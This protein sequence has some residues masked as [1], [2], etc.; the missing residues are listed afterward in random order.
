MNEI[1]KYEE[2]KKKM[3]G[4]CDEHGLVFR[5]TKNRY[6]IVF[7][8]RPATDLDSQMDMLEN[9]E[10]VGYRSPDAAMIWTYPGK[11]DDVFDTRV[12]G[13]TFTI[14]RNLRTKI[15]SILLKMISF[16]Q[17]YF[18]RDVMEKEAIKAGMEPVIDEDEA[19][20]DDVLPDDDGELPMEDA[21]ELPGDEDLPPLEDEDP[22]VEEATKIVRAENKATNALLQ[23]RM[24]I[25]Y[26]KAARLMNKLEEMGVVG[27]FNGPNSREVLPYD[28][29]EDGEGIGNE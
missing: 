10:D 6:P 14:G 8:I 5:L 25:G 11:G 18:F 24:N 28:V 16:W 17:Q 9:E 3:Q 2:Q 26:A 1:S 15:E 23:R 4:L 29:P 12:T 27:E 22:D 20:D 21:G 7:T 13:G 19:E